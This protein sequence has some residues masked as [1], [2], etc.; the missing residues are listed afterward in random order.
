MS[1]S[2]NVPAAHQDKS[3]S[4]QYFVLKNGRWR[5]VDVSPG[6]FAVPFHGEWC[7]V[8]SRM[9][10]D[11][12]YFRNHP[13]MLFRLK[14][15]RSRLHSADSFSFTISTPDPG[16]EA[17]GDRWDLRDYDA[18]RY[19]TPREYWISESGR[20]LADSNRCPGSERWLANQVARQ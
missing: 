8:F 7:V 20:M 1:T 13:E 14:L 15:H 12:E 5:P 19:C 16:I 18:S 17:I 4:P 3:D 2:I 9:E 11:E 6:T 10:T